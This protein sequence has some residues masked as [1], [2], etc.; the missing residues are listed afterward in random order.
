MRQVVLCEHVEEVLVHEVRRRLGLRRLWRRWL[1]AFGRGHHGRRLGRDLVRAL[2]GLGAH[3]RGPPGRA[4]VRPLAK[5][6]LG[7]LNLGWFSA[8][9][10]KLTRLD[11]CACWD[12]AK[13][14]G[15]GR[16]VV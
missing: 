1:P 4:R 8:R 14:D 9:H 3:T 13:A 2:A 6:L 12:S 15:T 16:R 11:L 5:R 7:H 10:A